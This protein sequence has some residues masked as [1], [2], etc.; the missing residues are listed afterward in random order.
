MKVTPHVVLIGP[1]QVTKGYLL[2]LAL[3]GRPV[4]SAREEEP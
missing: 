3:T 4:G 1:A 2:L